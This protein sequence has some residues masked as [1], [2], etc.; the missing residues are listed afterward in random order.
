[1]AIVKLSKAFNFEGVEHKEI[2][3]DLDALKGSDISTAKK[4]WQSEGN[5][6]AAVTMDIDFCVHVATLACDH[7]IEFFK[8]LPAKDYNR[9]YSE[10]FSFLNG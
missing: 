9:V 4:Q 1:M 5:V 8:E 6:A 7:P 10:V 3:L 2:E